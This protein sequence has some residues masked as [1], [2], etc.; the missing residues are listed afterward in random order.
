MICRTQPNF[1][2][3]K[4]DRITELWEVRV[5][6]SLWLRIKAIALQ[7]KVTFSQITRYCSFVLAERSSLRMS[8]AL[9]KL[10][11]ADRMAYR[12]AENLHRHMVCFYG[13]DVR[14]LRLA[15]MQLG[16]T[17]SCLIRV[18]LHIYLR[19]FDME[20]HNHRNPTDVAL[21]WRG[22]KRAVNLL[23]YPENTYGNFCK[24]I[25]L[26]QSFPPEMRWGWPP[27]S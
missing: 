23:L 19:H 26:L 7:K 24:R 4:P 16:V 18:A 14:I 12:E 8:R 15:A 13:E 17:V 11:M 6:R 22:I 2:A 5:P 3:D 21:F 25:Y 10:V 27:G 9:Q 1:L 20:K